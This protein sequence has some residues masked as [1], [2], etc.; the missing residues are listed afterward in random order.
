MSD[1]REKLGQII[2]GRR[3]RR[4]DRRE[5][6]AVL[7]EELV[8]VLGK[9]GDW[10]VEKAW[11]FECGIADSILSWGD[12]L[13]GRGWTPYKESEDEWTRPGGSGRS[14]VTGREMELLNNNES[15]GM[16]DLRDAGIVLTRWRVFL[17]LEHGDN[18][19][20][21]VE[22]LSVRYLEKVE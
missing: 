9:E 7:A 2:V 16:A 22:D 21:A 1:D 17:R 15:T 13:L 11:D 18:V 5:E 6:D 20:A 14:A 8:V 10:S 19:E 3:K 12:I 4:E